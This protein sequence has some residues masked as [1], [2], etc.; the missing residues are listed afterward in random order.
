MSDRPL[1]LLYFVDSLGLG[2]ANQ[3]TATVALQMRRNGH[4][5]W[6]A[7]E[8]G[9]LRSRLDQAGVRHV[10]VRTKVRHPSPAAIRLLA[11]TIREEKID[12]VCPN[13]F[14]CTLDAVP[15]GLISGR[16]ILPTYGGLISPPY[17]HPWLPRVN[18]FSMELAADLMNR[19]GWNPATFHNLIARIDADRFNPEVDGG[20]YREQLGVS[21]DQPIL[22]M[23]CRQ[24]DTKFLGV[25]TLLDAAARIH[26]AVPKARIVLVGDGDRRDDILA[27]IEAIE[28]RCGERFIVAPGATEETAGAFASA[29]VVVANGARSALE[30]MACAKPVISV[31]PNGFCGA[32]SAETI[33]GFRRFNFD[34]G[35]LAGNPLGDPANLVRAIE[36]ILRDERLRRRLCE[37][38]LSYAANHLLVQ[39]AAG[40]YEEL[41]REA[42][43][44]PW[45]DPW[46]R[47]RIL[48]RWLRSVVRFYAFR[49]GRPRPGKAAT[50]P[51]SDHDRLTPPPPGLDPDWRMGLPDGDSR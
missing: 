13:G 37:F 46:C 35:R 3:T 21:A 39:S 36:T 50:S 45:P 41:Y 15:A 7:S 25:K 9:P 34:K 2:G 26:A 20:P 28:A 48:T 18:V 40:L 44:Q 42:V 27:R 14:D 51:R 32:F 8:D 33:E 47:M 17:P 16:P 24:D 43:A 11:R 6:F 38:S 29:D 31:G 1:R 5:V 22:L 49:I 10:P 30:A 19:Y 23:V 4:H 12:L